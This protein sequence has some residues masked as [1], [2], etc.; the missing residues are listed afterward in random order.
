MSGF[1]KMY[2]VTE[3]EFNKLNKP[4]IGARRPLDEQE[5]TNSLQAVNRRRKLEAISSSV[6]PAR[7]YKYVKQEGVPKMTDKQ[8]AKTL[9]A[10][11]RQ[12]RAASPPPAPA[13]VTRARAAQQRHKRTT[14]TSGEFGTPNVTLQQFDVGGTSTP[15]RAPA[16]PRL[17]TFDV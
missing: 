1:T 5:V 9:P 4:K 12:Q 16:I 11:A 8:V 17:Q 2:L 7:M 6:A 14:S 15:A 3:A 10:A 13:P